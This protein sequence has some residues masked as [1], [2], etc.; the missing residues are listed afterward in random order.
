VESR[1][2]FESVAEDM[3]ELICQ[4]LGSSHLFCDKIK[5]SRPR[6][7]ISRGSNG[8]LNSMKDSSRIELLNIFRS[9]M[10]PFTSR[11]TLTNMKCYYIVD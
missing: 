3:A 2:P 8:G 11:S 4:N 5:H 6:K 1:S 9:G 7:G 10:S